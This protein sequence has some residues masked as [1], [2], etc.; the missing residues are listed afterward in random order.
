MI[1][2]GIAVCQIRG[3]K[4]STQFIPRSVLSP[5]LS[6]SPEREIFL[7]EQTV[8]FG[9]Y[10]DQFIC[11]SQPSSDGYFYVRKKKKKYVSMHTDICAH[12]SFDL[13]PFCKNSD[14]AKVLRCR[15]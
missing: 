9:L 14:G 6:E 12:H 15:E 10:R 4:S 1:G 5:P 11:Q 7:Q 8:F 13:F 3:G 2:E